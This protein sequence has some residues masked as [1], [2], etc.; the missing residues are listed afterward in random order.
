MEG[1]WIDHVNLAQTEV[2]LQ[3]FRRNVQ[4]CRPFGDEQWSDRVVHRLGLE[5]TIRP[6]GRPINGS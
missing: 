4:R 2:E 6:Q 5:T 1:G 3:A